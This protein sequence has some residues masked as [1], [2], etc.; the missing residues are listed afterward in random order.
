[1]RLYLDANPIINGQ[2]TLVRHV[3]HQRRAK[4]C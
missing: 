2:S 4:P 3:P 1:M